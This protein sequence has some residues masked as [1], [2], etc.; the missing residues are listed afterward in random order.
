[1]VD[2]VPLVAASG[3]PI[4][5]PRRIRALAHPLRIELIDVLSDAPDGLTATEC[6]ARTGESVAS[7][8]FHLRTLARYGYVEPGDR[9][10]REKPWRLVSRGHDFRAALTTPSGVAALEEMISYQT[11]YQFAR[12]RDSIHALGADTAEWREA[13]TLTSAGFWATAGELAE[14]QQALTAIWAR[15][16]K[17]NEQPLRRPDGARRINFFAAA[18]VDY[19]REARDA[20]AGDVG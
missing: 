17:R 6:A 20:R 4:A 1:M 11:D 10:G 7:C 13:S 9:R 5:D 19:P 18:L 2:E 16:A 14:V 12:L 15:F 3:E 8:S